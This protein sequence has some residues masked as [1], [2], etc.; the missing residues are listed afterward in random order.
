MINAEIL[1]SQTQQYHDEVE[2]VM[3]SNLIFSKQYT[4]KHY[5][6]F[7]Q[8]SYNHISNLLVNT[9]SHWSKYKTLLKQ[10]E[11]AL[12][13]DLVHLHIEGQTL[14]YKPMQNICKYQEL[15]FLYI[16]LGAM[17]GNKIIK[18]KLSETPGFADFPFNY[19]SQ[20]QEQLPQIWQEF[21]Q[22]INTLSPADLDKVI[23]SAIQGYQLFS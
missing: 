15:G 21:K 18:V 1:K 6:V 13:D 23:L 19:L 9:T 17:M 4:T 5:Q 8:R 7:L 11:S 16:V 2:K 20:H 10:K 14:E 3:Q 22:D 12:H